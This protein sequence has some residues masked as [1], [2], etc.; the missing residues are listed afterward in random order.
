MH[1]FDA[2]R[3]INELLPAA[4]PGALLWTVGSLLFLAALGIF[5]AFEA[6]EL[7]KYLGFQSI[8]HLETTLDINQ[9]Q[10]ELTHELVKH[11]AIHSE[12]KR[13]S[14]AK[15]YEAY[16]GF[17]QKIDQS[18]LK[19]KQRVA[20][21]TEGKG[22]KI[23]KAI[24]IGCGM[25]FQMAEMVFLTVGFGALTLSGPFGW[26]VIAATALIGAALFLLLLIK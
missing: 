8:K 18:L 9:K 25:I 20:A 21:L 13:I 7:S 11:L 10:I 6:V 22:R 4:M 3:A 14:S 15:E 26:L 24:L 12:Q 16:V 23:A 2:A 17:V 1:G 19:T 5:A